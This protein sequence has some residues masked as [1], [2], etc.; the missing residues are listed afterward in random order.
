MDVF[1]K[2]LLME[3]IVCGLLGCIIL[4]IV[5]FDRIAASLMR[6][7][8]IRL[9]PTAVR[10]AILIFE[11]PEQWSSDGHHLSHKVIGSIWISNAAYGLEVKTDM[12]T[13][14]PNFIERRIIRDA[15]DWR[16]KHFL[17][18]RITQAIQQNSGILPR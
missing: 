14:K 15:V 16:I 12:G 18:N 8:N 5:K 2:V 13:W 6:W 1:G 3:G 10:I 7:F 4:A 11:H 9:F 17:K